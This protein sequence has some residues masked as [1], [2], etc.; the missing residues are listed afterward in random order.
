MLS[1]SYNIEGERR[2]EREREREREKERERDAYTHMCVC[3]GFCILLMRIHTSHTPTVQR[4]MHHANLPPGLR[5]QGSGNYFS[6][7]CCPWVSSSGTCVAL[8]GCATAWALWE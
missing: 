3:L 8:A 7:V 5:G 2:K 1:S 6:R 4:Y